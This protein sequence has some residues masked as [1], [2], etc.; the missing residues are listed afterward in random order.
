MTNQTDTNQLQRIALRIREM[1]QILGFTTKEMAEKTDLS[2]EAYLSSGG[3]QED[4]EIIRR[5]VYD[6]STMVLLYDGEL[7]EATSFSSSGG[8]TEAAIAVWGSDYPYLQAVSSPEETSV[9]TIFYTREEFE[10]ILGIPA[11]GEMAQW[12]GPVV[13]TEGGGVASMEI[14][15]DTY[16][17]V[18]LRA[19]FGLRSTAF[20]IQTVEKGIIIT[21]KGYGHRVGMSQYGA[22]AMAEQGSTWQQ[23]LQ[24]YYPGTIISPL[25]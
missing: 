14:C 5:S 7:F 6:T 12:F 19:L 22:N 23:I 10:E 9:E 13:Y 11:S 16:T 25:F 20:E 17:G 8:K 18:Q 21:T 2:E 24:H 4:L 15:G 1:R 3:S